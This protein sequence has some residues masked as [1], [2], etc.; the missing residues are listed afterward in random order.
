MAKGKKGKNKTEMSGESASQFK[1]GWE[2]E[3]PLFPFFSLFFQIS[4]KSTDKRPF[5]AKP[6]TS[7]CILSGISQNTFLKA[8]NKLLNH[9]CHLSCAAWVDVNS[10]CPHE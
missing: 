9:F 1:A 7:D 8:E 3:F 4:V 2:L 6:H 5:S 10:E